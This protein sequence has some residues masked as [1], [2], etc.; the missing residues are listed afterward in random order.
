ML[1]L[2]RELNACVENSL[3]AEDQKAAVLAAT[4]SVSCDGLNQ[5]P[6]KMPSGLETTNWLSAGARTG[7][8]QNW[9]HWTGESTAAC[10]YHH[11][12]GIVRGILRRAEVDSSG[13]VEKRGGAADA[14]R[15]VH[16][17]RRRG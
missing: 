10:V 11:R 17:A 13:R 16:R 4:L 7:L 12:A 3:L 9:L 6:E 1:D 14:G 2:R 15:H 5:R 8:N